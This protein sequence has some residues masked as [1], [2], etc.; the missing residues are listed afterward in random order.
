MLPVAVIV[1]KKEEKKE[2]KELEKIK[3]R[4]GVF[5]DG[6]L[7]NRDNTNARIADDDNY[8]DN[9]VEKKDNSYENDSTNIA[10]MEKY[11]DDK[12]PGFK[13]S[14]ATYIEGPGTET[15]DADETFGYAF[16]TM[17]TGVKA[18]VHRGMVKLVNLLSKAFNGE[19]YIIE[20]LVIDVFGFS[21][22]AAGA[23]F[24]IHEVFN[25]E[26]SFMHYQ[27]QTIEFPANPLFLRL[28]RD[29]H[30]ITADNVSFAF[31]GLY[32]TVA[33]YG[34]PFWDSGTRLLKLDSLKDSRVKKVIHLVAADEHR[35]NF[36]STNIASA[37]VRGTEIFLPGVHSDL[38]GSYLKNSDEFMIINRAY[39]METLEADRQILIEQGW[40][41]PGEIFIDEASVYSRYFTISGHVAPDKEAQHH[42]CVRKT[43]INNYYDKIPMNIMADFAEEHKVP[44]IPEFRDDF[45]VH[46]DV[47]SAFDVLTAYSKGASELS[48]WFEKTEPTWL[49]TLR[50]NSFHFSAHYT[51]SFG[52]APNKPNFDDDRR[53][54]DFI[55]G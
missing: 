10:K 37:G 4:C 32:D 34:V 18:K 1:E 20:E 33:S 41:E 46:E 26:S 7:N 35:A 47:N 54:R 49:T 15:Y 12:A 24:F 53:I 5:F 21:R 27:G 19:K 3:V 9:K 28:Q 30:T 43:G 52:I 13:F 29:G 42:L 40:Y 50:H 2:A 22:G 11:I 55:P 44:L 45:K 25:E 51:L 17:G 23:R 6:T 39:K 38:G 31:A 48:D 36:P 14:V 16:G 8:N